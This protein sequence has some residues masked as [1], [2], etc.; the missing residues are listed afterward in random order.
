MFR[1][2]TLAR[3]LPAMQV[4]AP[5]V[6]AFAAKG[7][8]VPASKAPPAPVRFSPLALVLA[9]AAGPPAPGPPRTA[10]PHSP[11]RAP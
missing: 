11:A 2:L 3:R 7:G 5:F 4:V 10:A 6:R 1:A 8:V 9:R